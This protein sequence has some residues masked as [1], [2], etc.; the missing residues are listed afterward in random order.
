MFLATVSSGFMTNL[1]L[2]VVIAFAVGGGVLVALV[3]RW[4][5]RSAASV[6]L[7]NVTVSRQWLMQHKSHDR[8]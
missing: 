2:G 5:L 8:S 7:S 6:D 4:V 1:S 3:C